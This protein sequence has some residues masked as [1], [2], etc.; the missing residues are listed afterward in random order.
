[1]RRLV[2]ADIKSPV[3]GGGL[4]GHFFAVAKNYCD[5][6][7]NNCNVAVAGG[8]IYQKQFKNEII[9]LPFNVEVRKSRL[10]NIIKYLFNAKEL[11]CQSEDDTIVV[12]QGG[13]TT[14]FV[15]CALMCRKRKRNKLYLIQYS[16]AAL[17][18]RGKRM[19]YNLAK[20]YID[21]IICPNAEIGK[22]FGR[23]Y[24][25]V[26]DYIYVPNETNCQTVPY[27]AKQYD[28]CILGRIVEE[29]GIVEFLERFANAPY[30]MIIAGRAATESLANRLLELTNT[31]SNITLRLE[32]LSAGDYFNYLRQSRFGVL[33]YKEE[34][35]KRS[36]GVVLDMLYHDVPIIG[37]K[38]KA[39]DFI[40]DNKLGYIYDDLN[41]LD[42]ST[43]VTPQMHQAYIKSIVQYKLKQT[44]YIDKLGV[45]LGM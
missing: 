43:I 23:P 37:L 33:N 12:Q 7:A 45:F 8:P 4:T 34:Y 24:C 28:I 18:G 38:C 30:K 44:L 11:F 5:M 1:M 25:V 13:D 20:K 17:Q 29:K 35:S 41:T 9:A 36:S 10:A 22:A 39:F 32:F 16:T 42:L 6:F 14:F 31:H 40:C 21:G 15:A 27:E 3:V 2:I 19:L 26:P